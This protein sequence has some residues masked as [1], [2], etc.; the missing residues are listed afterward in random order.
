MT[1]VCLP[2][3]MPAIVLA[4]RGAV[5]CSERGRQRRATLLAIKTIRGGALCW[6]GLALHAYFQLGVLHY[7]LSDNS[8]VPEAVGQL[9]TKDPHVE[10]VG[11]ACSAPPARRLLD[12]S[13]NQGGDHER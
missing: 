5:G 8:R 12:T 13:M 7:V 4:H 2:P 3:A 9:I 10:G 1:I 6:R 11:D